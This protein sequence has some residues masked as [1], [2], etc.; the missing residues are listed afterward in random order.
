MDQSKIESRGLE[1]LRKILKRLDSW[2]FLDAN[3]SKSNFDWVEF[4]TRSTSM[5]F[6]GD[7]L[8]EWI[9][10]PVRNSTQI[11]LYF[12]KPRLEFEN[13]IF[14]NGLADK[15]VKAYYE[16]MVDTAV[17]LGSSRTKAES[18]LL[19]VLNFEKK[20]SMVNIIIRSQSNSNN[21]IDDFNQTITTTDDLIKT[22][23]GIDWNRLINETLKLYGKSD[24][25]VLV[26][27]LTPLYF[28]KLEKVLSNTSKRILANYLAWKVIKWSAPYLN[29]EIQKLHGDY[30]TKIKEHFEILPR[31]EACIETT[32]R[33]LNLSINY[34]YVKEYFRDDVKEN[35]VEMVKNIKD[36]LIN[37]LGAVDWLDEDT[38]E[39]AVKKVKEMKILIG[40]PKKILN[41]EKLKEYYQNLDVDVDDDF[42]GSVLSLK[43]FEKGKNFD[44]KMNKLDLLEE[45]A[46]FYSPLFVNA[47]YMPD[48]NLIA[49]PTGI[50]QYVF[51][52]NIRPNYINY[53]KIGS[54][55]G[56]EI[57]HGFDNRGR[58]FDKNGNF[59]DWWSA[60]TNNTY[61][62][63]TTCFVNQYNNYTSQSQSK[64]DGK[65]T[66]NENIADIIGIRMA[67][68]A[69]QKWVSKNGEEMSLP[70]L[71]YTPN[72]LF[73][74][75]FANTWC[76]SKQKHGRWDSLD[77]HAPSDVRVI[78]T[79]SNVPEFSA[80]FECPIGSNMNPIK[81]C[82]IW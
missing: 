2:P 26:T 14:S 67:Y 43:L 82:T 35:V 69:Y 41:G 76:K 71:Q 39:H 75:Y 53:G 72:Q 60:Y 77:P 33:F 16:Y 18:E 1:P 30:M 25:D 5:G 19:R 73:W 56:H 6:D 17:L 78:G 24:S 65:L 7:Y 63:K 34:L 79:L 37:V 11:E 29:E 28:S 81:K 48:F 49:I 20:L 23:P 52:N 61:N 36:M 22:W 9:I 58:K 62:K 32:N 13:E 27:V 57:T 10:S 47:Y 68:L 66:L 38:K 46:N 21:L 42:I 51:Y 80:D 40:Y 59:S 74:I 44:L 50:L 8:L 31:S 64:V 3:S 15:N 45:L 70:E 12:S 54:I 55:I 4:I